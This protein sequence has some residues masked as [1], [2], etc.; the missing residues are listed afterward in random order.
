MKKRKLI[1]LLLMITMVL[2]ISVGCGN[3]SVSSQAEEATE[4]TEVVDT[5]LV[6]D[7]KSCLENLVETNKQYFLKYAYAKVAN[8]QSAFKSVYDDTPI[9]T[10]EVDKIIVI[11]HQH[12]Y[13]STVDTKVK[14]AKSHLLNS[15]DILEV[16]TK[17]PSE[18]DVTA[19]N[20]AYTSYTKSI[21]D[22]SDE[23]G[24]IS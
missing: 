3:S 8:T 16:A 6:S 9:L 5:K 1:S 15:Q 7:I 4:E 2:P 24:K 21:I 18:F 17:A 20:E 11:T 10:E 23:A 19:F 13:F 12:S 14:E 22:A